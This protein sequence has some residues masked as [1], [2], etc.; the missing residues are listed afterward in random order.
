MK[1]TFRNGVLAKT[2]FVIGMTIAAPGHADVVS[3][4]KDSRPVR[5]VVAFSAGGYTDLVGRVMANEL[6]KSSSRSFIVENKAGANGVIG[7]ADVAR[8]KPDGNT[9]LLA[10]PGHV[11]NPLIT[12]DVPY[13]AKADFA[14]ILKVATLP[15]VLMVTPGSPFKSVQDIIKAAKAHPGDLTYASG[16][17]G[18]SNHLAMELM[19]K[20]T[21]TSLKHIPYKG[22]SLAETDVAGGHVQ[23]M[24]SGAGSAVTQV[25][26]GKLD[27]LAVSSKERIP[28]LP[29]VPTLAESGVTGYESKSWLGL[30]APANTPDDVIQKLNAL[31]NTAMQS[32]EVLNRLGSLGVDKFAPNSVNE[33]AEFLEHETKQQKALVASFG[34]IKK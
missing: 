25:K 13:D 2:A 27:A 14:P 5:I 3:W 1:K 16:G 28:S 34:D 12:A 30:F 23:M 4:E 22:S 29:D 7:T 8:S 9:L 24:F 20:M 32:Q 18:S 15:N 31:A 17:I 26:G 21:G 19:M 10:A 6:T 11:T 33:F